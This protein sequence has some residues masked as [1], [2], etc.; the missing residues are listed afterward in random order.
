M[1]ANLRGERFWHEAQA[2]GKKL[3][4]QGDVGCMGQSEAAINAFT[5]W[6]GYKIHV[7]CN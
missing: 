4:A 6:P 5:S 3:R 2:E 7:N 1:G